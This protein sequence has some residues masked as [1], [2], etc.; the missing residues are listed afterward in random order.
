VWVVG[1]SKF[2]YDVVNLPPNSFESSVAN[3][4]DQDGNQKRQLLRELWHVSF[5]EKF[6]VVYVPCSAMGSN[7]KVWPVCRLGLFYVSSA[8][9]LLRGTFNSCKFFVEGSR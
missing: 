9:N 6:H 5:V 8:Y 7:T 2:I 3:L 4:V 1:K